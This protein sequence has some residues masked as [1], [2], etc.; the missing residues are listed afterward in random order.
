MIHKIKSQNIL[1]K[2]IKFIQDNALIMIILE[3]KLW[4]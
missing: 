3:M 1:N 2:D 4:V